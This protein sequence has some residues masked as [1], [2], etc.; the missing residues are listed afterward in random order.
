MSNQTSPDRTAET[1]D[2]FDSLEDP[3]ELR[4][5]EGVEATSET[6]EHEDFDHCCAELAGRVAVAVENDDGEL[7]LLR[8]DDLGIAV[9]PHGDVEAGED[10]A[11]VARAET[12]ALTGVSVSLDAVEVLREIDHDV[13]GGGSARDGEIGSLD[14]ES[15]AHNGGGKPHRTTY[16]LVFAGRA[17]G[18]EIQDCKRSTEA[19]SDAW[20]ACWASDLPERVEIPPGG[21]GDDLRYVLD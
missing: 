5:V 15:S 2:M 19:G 14:G 13:E 6:R 3:V 20:W 10:W 4:G 17:V 16:R 11:G 7:L 8:N 12:E 1:D 21:P 9:L 18:G